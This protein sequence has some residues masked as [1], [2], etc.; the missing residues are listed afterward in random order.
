MANVTH[1]LAGEIGFG[2]E[3]AARNEVPLDFGEPN[4]DLIKPG[5][6]GRSVMKMHLG[7]LAQ[8]GRDLSG[9]MSRKV[10]HD[11]MD[12]L[13]WSDCADQLVQKGNEL[14]AGMTAG[15]FGEH[16]PVGGVQGGVERKGAVA[17]IF[18]A[19]TFGPS[20]RKRQDGIEPVQRLDGAFFIHAE[21]GGM[22]GRPQI[23]TNDVGGLLFKE[24]IVTAHVM[25]PAV[26]LQS[27]ASPN[28]GHPHVVD[29][30]LGRQL[31]AAPMAGSVCGL[32]MQRPM[33]DTSLDFFTAWM[34]QPSSVS[35]KETREPL[36]KEA[37]TPQTHRVNAAAFA[38]ANLTKTKR[39]T[40]HFQNEVCSTHIFIARAA[41]AAHASK[42]P[43]LKRSKNNTLCHAEP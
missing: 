32:A 42:C 10:V 1:N 9:F 38:A 28:S 37:L 23:K 34:T 27:R 3:D 19:M 31:A 14:S 25:T 40:G 22:S 26:G 17:K 41:A 12:L 20:R 8:E 7:A 39:R 16:F 2:T 30:Q 5:G 6:I 36:G 15:G 4:L 13:A 21:D 24:R 29:S 43:A 11:N 33:E 18:K 35:A